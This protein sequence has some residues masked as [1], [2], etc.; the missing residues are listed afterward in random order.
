MTDGIA[1]HTP[2][3]TGTKV[4]RAMSV[5]IA[6]L[7]HVGD[8]L[9]TLLQ[10]WS[11]LEVGDTPDEILQECYDAIDSWYEPMIIGQI[12]FFAGTL[13]DGWLAFNGFTWTKAEYP[14]LWEA[15]ADIYKDVPNETFTL[16]VLD[17][18]FVRVAGGLGNVGALGG[19]STVVLDETEI[20]AHTHN[21]QGVIVDIDVK[22]VGAPDPYG[23]RLG[24]M[25]PTTIT[26]GGQ[27]HENEPPYV[28]FIMGVFSGRA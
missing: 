19:A 15:L 16:P 1:R 28:E 27:A 25:T 8:A 14:E 3:L 20:P 6:L 12:S 22:T 9:A 2:T 7:P 18:R 13:P 4:V 10:E 24:V 26:G 11:W 21:Y 17:N 23:A 5:D